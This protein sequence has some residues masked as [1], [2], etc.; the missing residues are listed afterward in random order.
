[1]QI[2]TK[3]K[4]NQTKPTIFAYY[5]DE[6]SSTIEFRRLARNIWRTSSQEVKSL[7][8]TSAAPDEGKTLLA[9]NLAITIAK[10]ENKQ[11][12]LIDFDLRRP[13]I[14]SLFGVEKDVGLRALLMEEATLEEAIQDTELENLKIITSERGVTSPMQ[15][16]SSE[17]TKEI[18]DE[19]K[20]QFDLVI[21]DSPPAVAVHDAEILAPYVDG[22]LLVVL[23]G[24]TFREVV[25]RALELFKEVQA[26]VL[27]IVLNDTQGML[28]YYYQPKYYDKYYGKESV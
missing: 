20:S 12:R 4:K 21:C 26:N 25:M 28:P 19:C 2:L 22:V 24:K 1:M 14:H 23:T 7:L 9:S 10:S 13:A 3:R 8:V 6:S 15:L 18:L 16:L 27:G 5:K 11:V 17:R